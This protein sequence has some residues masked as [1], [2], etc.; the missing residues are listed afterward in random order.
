MFFFFLK[1]FC[2]FCGKEKGEVR[3]F[4]LTVKSSDQKTI[5]LLEEFGV[6]GSQKNKI[7]EVPKCLILS[8]K[9]VK[10]KGTLFSGQ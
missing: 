6:E 10:E 2:C 7:L 5:L 8:A 4:L 9:Q 1:H 3:V